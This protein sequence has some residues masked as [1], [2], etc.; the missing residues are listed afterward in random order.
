MFATICNFFLEMCRSWESILPLIK[1]DDK[2][3]REKVLCIVLK[4]RFV[5]TTAGILLLLIVSSI[6][7]MQGHRFSFSLFYLAPISLIAW[8]QGRIAGIVFAVLSAMIWFLI[9]LYARGFHLA[10]WLMGWNAILRFGFFLI[11][12]WLLS[13]LREA[14]SREQN[15]AR[16]D[17]LTQ[18][19]NRFAFYELAE[20]EV[21]RARRYQHPLSLAYIDL[22]NF[23]KVNDRFGH[24][25]GDELLKRVV[26]LI[27]SYIRKT[28]LFSRLGGDEFALLLP[29][30]PGNTAITLLERIQKRSAR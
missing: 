3:T 14:Y 12:T 15:L 26:D 4:N 13:A 8:Y 2:F 28:D 6:D 23:K 30:T 5:N 20:I 1:M 29:Q 11:T 19:W 22:D 27:T 24:S 17:F 10:I 7:L 18:I 25:T 9:D 16:K 21:A